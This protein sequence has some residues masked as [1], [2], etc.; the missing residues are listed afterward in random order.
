MTRFP[1]LVATV[2]MALLLVPSHSLRSRER[3]A[4]AAPPL[5]KMGHP[6]P[7]TAGDPM[8]YECCDA[9]PIRTD[10]TVVELG[11]LTAVTGDLHNR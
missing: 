7:P 3:R 6:A 8:L 9:Q 11:Y 5:T 2:A 1:L 4:T 10:R